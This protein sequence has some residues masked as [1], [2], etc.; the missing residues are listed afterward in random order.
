MQRNTIYCCENCTKF[1]RELNNK[2]SIIEELLEE[3]DNCEHWLSIPPTT[4]SDRD[5]VNDI[6]KRCRLI[7]KKT[8]GEGK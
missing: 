5:C 6:V 4:Q 2:D 8:K 3:L 1:Q 7:I